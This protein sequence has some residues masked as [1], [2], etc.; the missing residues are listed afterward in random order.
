MQ[1]PAINTSLRYSLNN[2]QNQSRLN[3]P[4]EPNKATGQNRPVPK[5]LRPKCAPAAL[6]R[7]PVRQVL[8]CAVRLATYMEVR[9][10]REAGAG[11]GPARISASN[12]ARAG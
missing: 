11:S 4:C 5:G 9:V 10:P 1:I 8:C 2:T 12:V 3:T 7:L 6:P